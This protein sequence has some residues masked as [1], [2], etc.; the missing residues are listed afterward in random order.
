MK[1]EAIMPINKIL[2]YSVAISLFI[3][4]AVLSLTGLLEWQGKKDPER[5]MTLDLKEMVAD[6]EKKPLT[7]EAPRP[8]TRPS[9]L[10]AKKTKPQAF[11]G[12]KIRDR[13]ATVNL[14]SRESR[15][16]PYLKTIR[17]K[18]ESAWIYPAK[19]SARKEEGTTI[20]RFSLAETGELVD[21][22]IIRSSGSPLLDEATLRAVK[23]QRFAPLPETFHLSRLNVIANFEYQLIR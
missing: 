6:I 15:Y 16:R 3:H 18:I 4:L 22:T 13:E 9:H 2:V 17:E 7:R 19:A 1:G 8:Q 12:G 10:P 23:T 20:I 14:N 11:A 5:V 21:T